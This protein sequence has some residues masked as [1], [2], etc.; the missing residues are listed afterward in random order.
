LVLLGNQD[1]IDDVFPIVPLKKP[2]NTP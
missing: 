2:K 1:S